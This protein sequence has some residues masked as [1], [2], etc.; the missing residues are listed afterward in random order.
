VKGYLLDT[1]VVS[2]L[3]KGARIDGHVAAWYA[4]RD[5][6]E[7]YLSVI[8]IAELRRGIRPIGKRDKKQG[9]IL[10]SWCQL[11]QR[12]YGRVGHLLSIRI[13]EAELWAELAALRPLPIMDAFIAATAK[14][15]DLVLVTRN[16]SDFK[17]LGITVENPFA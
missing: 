4:K 8:T 5:K 7:L 2:E 9:L 13:A 3:R 11:V 16:T 1:N 6:R 15:H 10:T 14:S 17:G 12:E